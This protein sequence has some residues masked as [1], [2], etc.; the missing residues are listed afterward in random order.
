MV[1]EAGM[2]VLSRCPSMP[3]Y[4]AAGRDLA[5]RFRSPADGLGDLADGHAF[6]PDGVEHRAGRSLLDGQPVKTRGVLHVDGGPAAGPV[7]DVARDALGPGHGDELRDEAVPVPLAVHRAGQHDQAGADA[8]AGGREG[9]LHVD[10]AGRDGPGGDEFVAFGRGPSGPDERSARDHQG[11]AGAGEAAG[12]RLDGPGVGPRRSLGHAGHDE[13]QVDDAVAAEGTGAQHA[14][15]V[16]VAAQHLGAQAGDC[17]GGG[18]R[19]GLARGPG[20]VA[21]GTRKRPSRR[22]RIAPV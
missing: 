16:Q 1:L 9:G 7:A 22:S 5:G 11:L 8:P 21:D 14:G 20:F 17:L 13:G 6:V 3:S 19:V 12:K 2:S 18:V 10:D 4:S 15:V